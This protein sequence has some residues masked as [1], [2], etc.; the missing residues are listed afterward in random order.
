MWSWSPK[1]GPIPCRQAP[2]LVFC[3]SGAHGLKVRCA[4]V[5]EAVA[6]CLA[7]RNLDPEL[8]SRHSNI[9]YF[10]NA[11]RYATAAQNA[12][13]RTFQP[14]KDKPRKRPAASSQEGGITMLSWSSTPF[15]DP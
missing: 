12:L 7:G 3:I 4:P 14:A 6:M 2:C 11:A 13:A 5:L 8:P 1:L 10:P 9:D 15:P